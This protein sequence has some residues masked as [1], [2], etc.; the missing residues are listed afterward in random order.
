M[1]ARYNRMCLVHNPR[2]DH[3]CLAYCI[4]CAYTSRRDHMNNHMMR[5]SRDRSR[6]TWFSSRLCGSL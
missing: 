4:L 1:Q 5:Y 6:R 2:R 3:M